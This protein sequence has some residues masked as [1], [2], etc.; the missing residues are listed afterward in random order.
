[1]EKLFDL[2]CSYVHKE[3][4]RRSVLKYCELYCGWLSDSFV[5]EESFSVCLENFKKEHPDVAL[6]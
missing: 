5:N 1:M 2:V 3:D 6:D 4:V